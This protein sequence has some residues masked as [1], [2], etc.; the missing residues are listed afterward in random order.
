VAVVITLTVETTVAVAGRVVYRNQKILDFEDLSELTVV[1]SCSVDTL[2]TV[3]EVVRCS[4]DQQYQ[5][6]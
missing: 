3:L 1:V 5:G 6:A 4:S 2:T